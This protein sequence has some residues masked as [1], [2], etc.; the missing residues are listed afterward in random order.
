[1]IGALGACHVDEPHVNWAC[2]FDASESRPTSDRDAKVDESGHLAPG[3][4]Q[5][6]C[7]PPVTSCLATTLDGGLSGAVCPVC[8][9]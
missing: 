1:M 8:S 6:T 5:S 9:F 7:G 2:D 4:C 3:E